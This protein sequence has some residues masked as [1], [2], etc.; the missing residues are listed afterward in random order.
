M[1][2]ECPFQNVCEQRPQ[3]DLGECG[4]EDLVVGRKDWAAQSFPN[5]SLQSP[6]G[7]VEPVTGFFDEGQRVAKWP[8]LSP[9]PELHHFWDLEPD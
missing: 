9:P 4:L 5:G 8:G 1:R 7:S 6:R 2:V 3:G